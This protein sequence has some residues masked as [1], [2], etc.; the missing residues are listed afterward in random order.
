M[1]VKDVR[2]VRV[3]S[4]KKREIGYTRLSVK[5]KRIKKHTDRA[6]YLNLPRVPAQSVLS[7]VQTPM[8]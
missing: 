1:L 7:I 3:E 5:K 8:V 6:K 4:F 2:Y